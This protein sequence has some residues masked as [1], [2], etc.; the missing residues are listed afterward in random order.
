M[1]SSAATGNGWRSFARSFRLRLSF[2]SNFHLVSNTKENERSYHKD[3]NEQDN[4]CFNGG[5]ICER[6]HGLFMLAQKRRVVQ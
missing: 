4:G 3:Q 5:L 2:R 6:S 1:M